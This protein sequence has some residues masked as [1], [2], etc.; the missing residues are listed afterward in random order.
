[1]KDAY[2]IKAVGAIIVISIV[3]GSIFAGLYQVLRQSANDPQIQLAEDL[4]ISL[5]DNQTPSILSENI[6]I[7]Q[8]LAP[9]VI[10]FNDKYQQIDSSGSLQNGAQLSPPK[11][12]FEHAKETGLHAFTWQPTDD[13]RF[14]TAVQPYKYGYVLSARSLKVVESR[15]DQILVICIIGWILAVSSSLGTIAAVTSSRSRR[16]NHS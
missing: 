15:I 12:V 1:M 11:G 16:S 6:N 9:F 4:A 14:A 8:S 7:E 10:V 13:L 5:S 3:F 2:V